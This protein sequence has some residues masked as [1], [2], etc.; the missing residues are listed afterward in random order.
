MRKDPLDLKTLLK[1]Q[2]I[3]GVITSGFSSPENVDSKFA[4]DVP[5]ELLEA[6]KNYHDSYKNLTSMIDKLKNQV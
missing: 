5:V 2:Q 1:L 4:P 3:G 6:W